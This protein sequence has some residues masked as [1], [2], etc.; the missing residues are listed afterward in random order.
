LES[1]RS[2]QS[3]YENAYFELVNASNRRSYFLIFTSSSG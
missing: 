3:Q 1:S 2:S